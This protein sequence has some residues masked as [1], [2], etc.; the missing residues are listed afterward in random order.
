MFERFVGHSM[1]QCVGIITELLGEPPPEDFMPDLRQKSAAALAA[2]VEPI[3]GVAALVDGL[4][5]P[6]CVASSGEPAKIRLTL[7]KTGLL[8]H[9]EGKL[10]SAVEVENPKPAPDVFLHA[11]SQ[12]GVSPE[13][14]AVIE[15]TPT[16]VKAGL[17]AGM[18]VYGFSANTPERRLVEAGAHEVFSDMA[19]LH[20]LLAVHQRGQA[21]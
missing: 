21:P 18:Y 2:E 8:G 10:F 7:G 11:A 17:A 14:C 5:I 3:A 16:G 20:P 13:L 1:P 6:Y 12:M 9:F 4:N 15:D 19:D